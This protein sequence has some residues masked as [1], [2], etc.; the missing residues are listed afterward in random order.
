MPRPL[1]A[2]ESFVNLKNSASLRAAAVIAKHAAQGEAFSEND[3]RLLREFAAET[4]KTRGSKEKLDAVTGATA[5]AIREVV[6]RRRAAAAE[7]DARTEEQ[8]AELNST[9][10]SRV[11]DR[12]SAQMDAAEA[13]TP[14]GV[15]FLATAR[16]Q[17]KQPKRKRLSKAKKKQR[18]EKRSA[19]RTLSANMRRATPEEQAAVAKRILDF[20]DE[21]VGGQ[22]KQKKFMEGLVKELEDEGIQAKISTMYG[23]AKKLDSVDEGE[24]PVF[25]MV[26]GVSLF[27][28][29]EHADLAEFVDEADD[30]KTQY[31]LMHAI[32]AKYVEKWRKSGKAMELM[33]PLLR[34]TMK[35][36]MLRITM[37]FDEGVYTQHRSWA[38]QTAM[39]SWR[40]AV[41]FFCVMTSAKD[42]GNGT[43]VDKRLSYNVDATAYVQEAGHV[44]LACP[45]GYLG[46]KAS[47]RKKKMKDPGKTS[48]KNAPADNAVGQARK[49]YTVIT[50]A[51]GMPIIA[52]EVMLRGAE[53]EGLTAAQKREPIVIPLPD[54]HVDGGDAK[55]VVLVAVWP[56]TKADGA[57]DTFEAV[58]LKMIAEDIERVRIAIAAESADFDYTADSTEVPHELTA[59]LTLDGAIRELKTTNKHFDD[60]GL[61]ANKKKIR[62]VKHGAKNTGNEQANDVGTGYCDSKKGMRAKERLTVR[63]PID[64]GMTAAVKALGDKLKALHAVHGKPN[65]GLRH[66][67]PGKLRQWLSDYREVVP[68]AFTATKIRA[69]FVKSGQCQ[70]GGGGAPR[71][72]RVLE[73]VN[74]GNPLTQ[75]EYNAV[76]VRLCLSEHGDHA[77]P[78]HAAHH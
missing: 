3:T 4:L 48:S 25:N 12:M 5:D 34:R 7:K 8:R 63:T 24:E 49:V 77:S 64:A 57:T 15:T 74:P 17:L 76:M 27:T 28:V 40:N 6:A 55:K 23:W 54:F 9:H 53:V 71:L 31:D 69:G 1:N 52:I 39:T 35:R 58:V 33:P 62:V 19:D 36:T 66:H 42:L 59:L 32:D 21:K 11:R 20:R 61:L 75:V 41:Q 14:S 51:G 13:Q 67:I 22:G 16:P 18:T 47:K 68:D 60:G 37:N 43:F 26:G 56:G 29:E 78:P 38:R 45:K 10:S 73:Q 44:G 70:L 50:E 65:Q 72:A 30:V 46:R 2:P